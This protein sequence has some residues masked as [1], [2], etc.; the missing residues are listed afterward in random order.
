MPAARKR[1][2]ASDCP[3]RA[4]G[5]ASANHATAL[6]G[7]NA[8]RYG[9]RRGAPVPILFVCEDN[10]IGIS[11]DTPRRWIERSF[12]DLPH[13]R[14]VRAA[15]ELDEIYVDFTSLAGATPAQ[16]CGKSGASTRIRWSARR[17]AGSARG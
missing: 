13:L 1:S 6:A 14:Y 9:H 4:F 7:L 5:D 17:R 11:V 8:A 15:G 3:T 16:T 10:G 12:G 2:T